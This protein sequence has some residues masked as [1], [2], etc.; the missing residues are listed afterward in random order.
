MIIYKDRIGPY[1]TIG[2]AKPLALVKFQLALILITSFLIVLIVTLKHNPNN[3][4]KKGK[5]KQNYYK[6]NRSNKKKRGLNNKSNLEKNLLSLFV[7]HL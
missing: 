3:N 6:L 7:H 1:P 5:M 2:R 4:K